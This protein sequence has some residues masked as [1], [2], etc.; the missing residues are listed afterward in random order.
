MFDLVYCRFLLIHV[1]DPVARLSE[2][3]RVSNQAGSP[4]PRTEICVR[5]GAR[6]RPRSIIEGLGPKKGVDYRL[7]RDVYHLVKRA[8]FLDVGIDIY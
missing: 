7:G 5:E 8:D 2:M 3:R 4:S 1:L 6:R